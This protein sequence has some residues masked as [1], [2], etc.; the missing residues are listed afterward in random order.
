[1][2]YNKNRGFII[3]FLAGFTLAII[4]MVALLKKDS[5]FCMIFGQGYFENLAMV[6]VDK[7]EFWKYVLINRAKL[8]V[9][10]F[11][12]GQVSCYELSFLIATGGVGAL[13]GVLLCSLLMNFGAG[14]IVVF[15]V[16]LLP[17]GIFYYICGY[18]IIQSKKA[19]RI[20]P[21]KKAVVVILII[22]SLLLGVTLESLLSPI[23]VQKICKIV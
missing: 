9:F 18:F 16:A 19:G 13:L 15:F 2:Q 7:L 12:I 1:M 20:M 4:V 23:L 14:G 3:S 10:W 22:L 17:Q 11:L 8:L 21:S 6:S 5:A